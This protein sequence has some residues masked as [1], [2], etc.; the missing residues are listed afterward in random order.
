MPGLRK[1]WCAG[2]AENGMNVRRAAQQTTD[3]TLGTLLGLVDKQ[4]IAMV[5][6]KLGQECFWKRSSEDDLKMFWKSVHVKQVF[7]W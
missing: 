4:L 7:G 5:L 2:L 1:I 3:L 6:V